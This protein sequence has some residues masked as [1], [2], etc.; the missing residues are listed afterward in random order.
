MLPS[1]AEAFLSV[2]DLVDLQEGVLPGVLTFDGLFQELSSGGTLTPG[3][4]DVLV[5]QPGDLNLALG[6]E[7]TE[8][9]GYRIT[10]GTDTVNVVG[11]FTHQGFK[12]Y[13]V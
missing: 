9:F 13:V 7:G 1:T 5:Y 12:D 8:L 2:A 10:N 3:N 4:P 6:E 11:S